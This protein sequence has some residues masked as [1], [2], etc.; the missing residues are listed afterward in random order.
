MVLE[1]NRAVDAVVLSTVL[2]MRQAAVGDGL[3]I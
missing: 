1:G 3:Q 2:F